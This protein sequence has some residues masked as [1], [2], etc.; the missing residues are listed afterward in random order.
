[1]SWLYTVKQQSLWCSL[2]VL[3]VEAEASTDSRPLSAFTP[4]KGEGI[5]LLGKSKIDPPAEP[6]MRIDFQFDQ[7]A[8]DIR[9]M[10]PADDMPCRRF[11][12]SLDMACMNMYA[13]G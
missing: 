3:R 11:P 10:P 13:C 7:A 9:Y 5:F 2:G 8:F 1:M 6:N 4:R 12:C